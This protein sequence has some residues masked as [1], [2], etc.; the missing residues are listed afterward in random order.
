MNSTVKKR[1]VLR[2]RNGQMESFEDKIVTEFPVTV[3]INEEEFVTMVCSPQYIEDMVIGYLASEGVIRAY[4]DIK[5]IW[6]QEKEGYVHVTIDKLNPYFQNLQNKRYITSCCGA[7]RQGFVFINDALTAKKMNDI[8]VELS[9]KDCFQLMNKLQ[10]S[11][12]TF[13]E[14]GGVHNAAICD[15]NGFMLSRMDI[16]RHNALDKLYG[17]CLKHHISIRDKVVVFSGRISSEILLKVAKIGCEVV[18]SKSAPTEL[19]LNLAEELGIT[20]VGFIRNDSLNIYTCP[21]RIL[22]ES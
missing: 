1:T 7:S 15:K 13:Q 5:N 16:G 3:K 18:L 11:A 19:A 12:A 8:S 9:I 2:F 14:T 21:E 4:K 10:Q 6:V 20:T 17:Y 22:R